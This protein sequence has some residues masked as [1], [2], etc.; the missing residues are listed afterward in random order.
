MDKVILKCDTK[1]GDY[2]LFEINKA[3]NDRHPLNLLVSTANRR[4]DV[5]MISSPNGTP[6]KLT[7]KGEIWEKD[8][9]SEGL[10]NK[11][12]FFHNLD[13]SLICRSPPVGG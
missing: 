12:Y 4:K 7:S 10:S 5:K 1:K 8:P 3:I 13:N 2:T 11:G 9:E 6:L